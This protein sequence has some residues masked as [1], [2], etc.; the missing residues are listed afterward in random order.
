MSFMPSPGSVVRMVD[1]RI[2]AVSKVSP[3]GDGDEVVFPDGDRQRVT[4]W[5]IREVLDEVHGNRDPGIA[6]RDY[7]REKG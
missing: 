1:G 2:A 4:A 5:G 7:L 6:L 3:S